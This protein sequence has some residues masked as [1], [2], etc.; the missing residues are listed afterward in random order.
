M[1]QWITETNFYLSLSAGFSFLVYLY[2]WP[3]QQFLDYAL[4]GE[5]Y[6]E[7]MESE[8]WAYC[9][10]SRHFLHLQLKRLDAV[11]YILRMFAFFPL[12]VFFCFKKSP[13]FMRLL[14][15]HVF[16]T[17]CVI[18]IKDKHLFHLHSA[19]LKQVVEIFFSIL[20]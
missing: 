17:I 6:Q 1:L 20:Q 18:C 9:D 15:L 16:L 3:G 14:F 7:F 13:Q 4:D 10:L 5:Y 8:R 19:W 2:T 12:I 11:F